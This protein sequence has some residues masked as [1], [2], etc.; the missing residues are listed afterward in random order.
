M[1]PNCRCLK[2]LIGTKCAQSV[3]S[4]VI[5]CVVSSGNHAGLLIICDVLAWPLSPTENGFAQSIPTRLM[6]HLPPRPAGAQPLSCKRAM[7]P[8]QTKNRRVV[9]VTTAPPPAPHGPLH[10][11]SGLTI[12]RVRHPTMTLLLSQLG[13]GSAVGTPEILK[14]IMIRATLVISIRS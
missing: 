3:E 2:L 6:A 9:P 5:C 4:E 1:M 13:F 10:R 14:Q 7:H 11:N 12:R 8:R